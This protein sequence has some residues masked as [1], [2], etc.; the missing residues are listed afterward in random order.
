MRNIA[1]VFVPVL[2]FLSG[3]IITY[4]V[5]RY[6]LNG[7]LLD[8]P[9]IRSSHAVPTP[10]GGGLA[11]PIVVVAV[12]GMGLW[13]YTA[14]WRAMLSLAIGVILIGGLGWLDD[15]LNLPAR[16]RL[17]I[18]TVVALLLVLTIGAIRTL[19]VA[20]VA[21]DLH[22]LGWP[23][24]VLWI[25]WLTNLYNFMDGIDGIAGIEA[26]IASGTMSIWFAVYGDVYLVVLALA[27]M[28]SVLGFLVWNWPPARI[29]MGDVGSV[30]LGLLFAILAIIG[31]TRHDMP[32]SGFIILLSVFLADATITLVLRIIRKERVAEAHKTHFYQRAAHS[33]WSH[34]QVTSTVLLVNV[35]LAI[36]A[37]LEVMRVQ[38][39]L[40][41]S[42]GAVLLLAALVMTVLRR[43]RAQAV[44]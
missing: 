17:A 3:L 5:R 40:L 39:L 35:L 38:P 15:H 9:N 31:V 6:A 19:E 29:F 1:V 27:I 20:G 32:W 34:K 4:L 22:W 16:L 44:V 37:T 24:T 10:R 33:G 8:I 42:V 25:V 14:H 36:L 7:A 11:I 23:L 26:V 13:V 21:L 18:Q 41:W 43:E 28:G 2:A 12:V 30:T